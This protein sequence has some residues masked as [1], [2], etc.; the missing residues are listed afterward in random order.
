MFKR[1]SEHRP[2]TRTSGFQCTCVDGRFQLPGGFLGR[3]GG[4]VRGFEPA[5]FF[6]LMVAHGIQRWLGAHDNDSLEFAVDLSG[7]APNKKFADI[8]FR[9]V[10]AFPWK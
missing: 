3:G 2:Q 10:A 4:D 7:F 8:K 9:H 1:S 6:D 5:I